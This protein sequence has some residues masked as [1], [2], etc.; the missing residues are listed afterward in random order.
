VLT[1]VLLAHLQRTGYYPAA[2]AAGLR[3]A[4]AEAG[5]ATERWGALA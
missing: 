1:G 3:E 2:A 5:R 4:V